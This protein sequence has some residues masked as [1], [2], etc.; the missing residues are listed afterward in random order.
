MSKLLHTPVHR[1]G[2]RAT[3]SAGIR[4]SSYVGDLR[5]TNNPSKSFASSSATAFP[6]SITAAK[7]IRN[8]KIDRRDDHRAADVRRAPLS[9]AAAVSAARAIPSA[10]ASRRGGRPAVPRPCSNAPRC[11]R[12]ARRASRGGARR[13]PTAD[14]GRP[15]GPRRRIQGASGVD[16]VR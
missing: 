8:S 11:R 5:C 3:H 15:P 14:R 10:V 7:R 2:L 12:S 16:R 1:I 13:R 6:S 9:T 4:W